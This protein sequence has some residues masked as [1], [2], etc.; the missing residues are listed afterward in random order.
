MAKIKYY[1][2]TT[3]LIYVH[4]IK[5][6]KF[7]AIGGVMSKDNYYDCCLRMAGC[8]PKDSV[9]VLPVT[10]K[11]EYKSN[12]SKHKCDARCVNAKGHSCECSCGGQFHGS[13][14]R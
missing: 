8:D 6:E 5:N 1:N 9:T 3:E 12:P 13:G 7:L 4:P 2:G 14:N 11:I 10:R